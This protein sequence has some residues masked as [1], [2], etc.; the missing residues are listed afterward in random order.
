MPLSDLSQP[1]IWP[2]IQCPKTMTNFKW[3]IFLSR[4]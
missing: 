4:A 1:K 3:N 2:L